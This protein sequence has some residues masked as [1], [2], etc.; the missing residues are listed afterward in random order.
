M[1]L[2]RRALVIKVYVSWFAKF[3]S[4]VS[5]DWLP[6]SY[7]IENESEPDLIQWL[8]KDVYGMLAIIVK[9]GECNKVLPRW[10]ILV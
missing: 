5:F 7:T 3:N 2:R 10:V 6:K 9:F 1:E 4:L 8:S